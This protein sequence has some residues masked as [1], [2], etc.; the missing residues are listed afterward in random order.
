MAHELSID[1]VRKVAR[2]S[3]LELSEDM[4]EAQRKRL[5]EVL[6]Y[7]DRLA[8]LDLEGVEPMSGVADETNRLDEDIPGETLPT[9]AL[10]KMAP[11][12]HAPFVK[13]P[14]VLGDGSGA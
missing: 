11:D 13:A 12:V 10:M 14:K 5:A 8:E 6:G 2:L 9:E 7:I 4:L 3:R 1:E